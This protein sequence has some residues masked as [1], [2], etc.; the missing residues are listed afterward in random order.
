MKRIIFTLLSACV[1][2][3]NAQLVQTVVNFD[4]AP[5]GPE[6]SINDSTFTF[7]DLTFHNYHDTTGYWYGFA[8]SNTTDDTTAGY[9]NQYSCISGSGA[10]NSANYM[11]FYN[12]NLGL[13]KSGSKH[14]FSMD[15]NNTTLAALSMRDGDAF[16]KKFGGASGNDPDF[17]LLQI[18]G[19]ANGIQVDD[20]IDFYL[21][22]FRFS[23][24]AQDYILD[25]WTTIDL[26]S[27]ATADSIMFF[28]QS[29]DVGQWG[30]NTPLYFALDNIKLITPLSVENAET[31]HYKVWP[32]PAVNELYVE[33][34]A[35]ANLQV[36]SLSGQVM[37]Q[38]S[39][40]S[41]PARI[42]LQS[43]QSGV[44]ILKTETADG[45]AFTKFVKR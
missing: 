39:T 23:N 13:T 44:Y 15:V 18:V 42:D 26:S 11:I 36:I 35:A 12:G 2:Q 31:T 4:S 7:D 10:E 17:L 30:I 25:S 6:S 16:A 41:S 37:A 19:Y 34:G 14:F 21:A 38:V 27:I 8:L 45:S 5:L 43:L 22:D 24:N 29:S 33:T 9:G 40:L 3:V 20:T 1:L 32:N 28:F